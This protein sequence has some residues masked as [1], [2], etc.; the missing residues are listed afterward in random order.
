MKRLLQEHRALSLVVLATV[1]AAG[2]YLAPY[3]SGAVLALFHHATGRDQLK[4][5]AGDVPQGWWLEYATLLEERYGLT[6]ELLASAGLTDRDLRHANGYNDVSL[7]FLKKRFGQDFLTKCIPEAKAR[8][9]EREKKRIAA[10][11]ATLK[12]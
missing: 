10:V 5:T 8:Y 1:L 2:W 7:A 4:C 6:V 3:P 12:R 11:E 9:V